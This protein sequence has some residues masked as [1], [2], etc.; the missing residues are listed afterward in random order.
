MKREKIR[1]AAFDL[2]DTLLLPGGGLS[3]RARMAIQKAAE[4]GIE[5]V[6]SSG[7]SFAS[8]PSELLC[9]PQIHYAV[10]SNGAAVNRVPSGRRILARCLSQDSVQVILD[11][12]KEEELVLEAFVEGVPY[13]W[14]AYLKNPGEYGCPAWSVPYVKR[15]RRPCEDMEAFLR[16]HR[17]ELDSVDLICKSPEERERYRRML[18]ERTEELYLTTSVPHLLE[19]SAA[20]GGKGSGLAW[21]CDRLGVSREE[22]AACGNGDNDADMLLFA[23]IGGA[24]A[25]ATEACRNAADV[26]LPSNGE[27]GAAVFL[28]SFLE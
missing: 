7:R 22:T 14:D 20:G 5:V 26:I 9:M 25:N 1:L 15:T 28:E 19:L 12:A 8:L 3:E 17:E 4:Q 16:R 23:G 27:D 6:L 11:L 2:D 18:E 10:T 24:V 21:L 13:A